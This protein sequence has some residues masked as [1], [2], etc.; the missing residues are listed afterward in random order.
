L[1]ERFGI[2]FLDLLLL[3]EIG[4]LAPSD[5]QFALVPTQKDMREVFTCGSTCVLL[6]RP[7]GTPEQPLDVIAFTEIGKELLQLVERTPIDPQYI[8]VFA[9]PFQHPGVVVKSGTIVQ[10]QSDGGFRYV[11]LHDVPGNKPRPDDEKKP[12]Q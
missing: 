10:W 12:N 7:A 5:L 3:R 6:D 11:G 9:R 1:E 4:L 2:R 8:E